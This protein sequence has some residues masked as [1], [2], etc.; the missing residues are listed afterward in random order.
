MGINISKKTVL[1]LYVKLSIILNM[2]IN[3]YLFYNF[4]EA[5]PPIIHIIVVSLSIWLLGFILLFILIWILFLVF[6][7][8]KIYK[9][10]K[11]IEEVLPD[12]LQLA[13]ANI[14]AGMTIDRA[15]WFAVRPRFGVLAKEIEIVVKSTLIGENLNTALLRFSKKYDSVMLQRSI[16]LLLEGL[17]AGGNVA[18]LLNKIAI[19]IQETKILK[20]EMAANV[21]TYVIFISFAAVGAAPFL[22]ALSTE[23]IVIMQS[24]MGNI[25]LGDSGGAMFSIDAEGLNLAEFKIFIY[26][27]MAVTSTFSAIIVSIIKKGNVKDGLQYIP[28]FIAISYFLYTVAFWMLSSAMGGMF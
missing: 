14:S 18:P 15:L 23:L 7:D 10:K 8:L 1:S 22:F 16:N 25:D 4:T 17:N 24:I 2:V 9:R 20:K 21:M 12:F 19:N 3:G 28:T 6:V 5:N 11:E 26:L 27:S 13:A